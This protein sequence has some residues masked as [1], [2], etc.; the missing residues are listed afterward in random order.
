LLVFILAFCAEILPIVFYLV[1]LKRNRG[2]GLWVIFLYCVFSLLTEMLFA[3]AQQQIFYMLF[4]IVQFTLFSFFFYSSLEGKKVK[5]IP[6]IGALV[7]YVVA[8]SNFTN[9]KFDSISVSLSSV[10][11]ITYC[12]LLLYELIKDPKIL[13]VYY[14]KKFW[15]I[16]AF[17]LYFSATF[18]LFL[19]ARAL[20]PTEHAKY[21]AINNFFEILK[22]I[23]FCIAFIMKKNVQPSYL[24]D[25]LDPD[26]M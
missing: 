9:K 20:T 6:I 11:I 8:I 13:F 7:F 23:L 22:N 19:Y 18:F 17:L 15:V 21:W 5:Y 1:F 14:Q 10:L 26:I 12:I 3:M 2:E 16:I 25:N 24:T 4:A